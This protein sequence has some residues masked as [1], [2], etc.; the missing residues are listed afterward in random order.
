MFS[1]KLVFCHSVAADHE[2]EPFDV[3]ERI[4]I[5]AD[6]GKL[7]LKL[8]GKIV[9]GHRIRLHGIFWGL[10][11]NPVDRLNIQIQFQMEKHQPANPSQS[12]DER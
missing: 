7:S 11:P 10:L 2:R 4:E 9:I 8:F 3:A 12:A 5:G 6:G 1:S